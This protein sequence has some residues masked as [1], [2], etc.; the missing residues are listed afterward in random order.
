V[1]P[2]GFVAMRTAERKK[3]PKTENAN[4]GQFELRRGKKKST[5]YLVQL[6]S[7]IGYSFSNRFNS[8][9]QTDQQKKIHKIEY[10]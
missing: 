2:W 7:L 5:P 9:P 4:G 1:G 3:L 6:T 10:Y 8:K